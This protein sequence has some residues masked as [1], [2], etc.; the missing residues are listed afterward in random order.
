MHEQPTRRI[1]SPTTRTRV[2]AACCLPTVRGTRSRPLPGMWIGPVPSTLATCSQG[3]RHDDLRAVNPA[4]TCMDAAAARGNFGCC[5]PLGSLRTPNTATGA[6]VALVRS[7]VPAEAEFCGAPA[8]PASRRRARPPLPQPRPTLRRVSSG[9]TPRLRRAWSR[10][11]HHVVDR[12]PADASARVESRCCASSPSTAIAASAAAGTC[13]P[14]SARPCRSFSGPMRA[15]ASDEFRGMPASRS[16][17]VPSMRCATPRASAASVT[18][19]RPSP[20]A[21]PLL[22]CSSSHSGRAAQGPIA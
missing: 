3:R 19:L 2:C 1:P 8:T 22:A 21:P 6:D 14:S 4:H 17:D 10:W 12:P 7:V 15:L 13:Y 18:P 5:I 16:V 9:G 20:V 11:C